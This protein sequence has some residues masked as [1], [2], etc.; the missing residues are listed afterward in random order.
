MHTDIFCLLA[1]PSRMGTDYHGYIFRVL[2]LHFTESAETYC[3]SLP[4]ASIIFS[5]N[6]SPYITVP[7]LS[8]TL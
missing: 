5:G 3:H 4:S 1:Q 7:S 8:Y 6:R 2:P